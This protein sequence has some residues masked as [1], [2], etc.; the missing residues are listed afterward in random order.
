MASAPM[1]ADSR[2]NKAASF[3]AVVL[4]TGANAELFQYNVVITAPAEPRPPFHGLIEL[5]PTEA[6]ERLAAFA[7]CT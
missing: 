7:T 4:F 5:R 2:R 1:K 6:S 3:L